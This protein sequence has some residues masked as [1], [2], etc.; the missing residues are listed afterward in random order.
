VR[1]IGIHFK[2]HVRLQGAQSMAHSPNIGCSQSMLLTFYE[3]HVSALG[4]QTPHHIGRPIW[5]VIV[6]YQDMHVMLYPYELILQRPDY[7]FYVFALIKCRKYDY[8]FQRDISF[9][10]IDDKK[11]TLNFAQ[12]LRRCNRQRRMR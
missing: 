3:M 10:S 9:L 11:W 8:R 7:C 6:N 4:P 1:K 12:S 5:R 2:Y